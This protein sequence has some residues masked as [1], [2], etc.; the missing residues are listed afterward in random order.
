MVNNQLSEEPSFELSLQGG[1]DD[2]LS[3]LESDDASF[4]ACEN[5]GGNEMGQ[6]RTHQQSHLPATPVHLEQSIRRPISC[7]NAT[8]WVDR[9]KRYGILCGDSEPKPRPR[10]ETSGDATSSLRHL[11]ANEQRR[12]RRGTFDLNDSNHKTT[13]I[14]SSL[15]RSVHSHYSHTKKLPRQ[16]ERMMAES[17]T[18]DMEGGT[19]WAVTSTANLS[20]PSLNDFM[21]PRP[22]QRQNSKEEGGHG[23]AIRNFYRLPPRHKS[24][25]SGETAFNQSCGSPKAF[26]RLPCRVRSLGNTA[27]SRPIRDL[28]ISK[29]LPPRKTSNGT[30]G[31]AHSTICHSDVSSACLTES[32][33]T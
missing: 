21:S 5:E 14:T 24:R 23:H 26:K 3:S 18:E 10:L 9:Q 13:S 25:D 30:A 2:S 17:R 31:T 12:S 19:R 29:Q 20:V 8:L 11:L 7:G 15:D 28:G 22:P 32:E 4:D 6:H 27:E 16:V 1:M 33:A